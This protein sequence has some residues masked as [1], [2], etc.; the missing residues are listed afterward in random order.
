VSYTSY[1]ILDYG[2]QLHRRS[3]AWHDMAPSSVFYCASAH[4]VHQHV[5]K[6]L[7]REQHC[8]GVLVW[9]Y[10]YIYMCGTAHYESP[11]KR[12]RSCA[13]GNNSAS[14]KNVVSSVCLLN[15]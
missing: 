1:S 6:A 7:M 3:V 14:A 9:W 13:H 5:P 4:L 12:A 15:G 11:S 8:A 10:V 2:Y